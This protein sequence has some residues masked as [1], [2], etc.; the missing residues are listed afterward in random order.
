M[1]SGRTEVKIWDMMD[2]IAPE[3]SA[4]WGESA[5]RV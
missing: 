4:L 1:C 5:T 2:W 3:L